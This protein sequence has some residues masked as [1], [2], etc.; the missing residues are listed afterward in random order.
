MSTK[1]ERWLLLG[2]VLLSLAL[3]FFFV[4]GP[5]VVWGDEPFYLW[6]GRNWLTGRG[7]Q[8]LGFTDVHHPPLYPLLSGMMYLV[9]RNLEAASNSLY[10]IFG[11][12]LVLPVYGIGR[13]LYGPRPGLLAGLLVALW[14]PF[15]AA[16]PW[17]GTMTEPPYY[18]FVA[19]GLWAAVVAAGLGGK[20]GAEAPTTNASAGGATGNRFWAWA[21]AG[22]AFGLAYLTRPEGLW[23]APAVGGA[24]LVV[25]W[26]RHMHWRG[27]A[28]GAA[29]FALGFLAGFV[30]YAI[31]TRINTG[32]WMVSEKVGITFQ[33]GL[34]IARGDMAEHDRVL[35]QLD[36][37]GKQVFFFSRESFHL[38]MMDQI[39]ADPRGYAGVLYLNAQNLLA[40]FFSVVDFV[41]AFL[42]LLGLGLFGMAWS[43]RRLYGELI[44]LAALLPPLT[45]LL[46]F[47]F[48]RYLSPMLL[49]MLVWTG[50]GLALMGDWLEETGMALQPRWPRL[51]RWISR[52]LLVLAVALILL[53]THRWTSL[54]VTG[55]QA[56]RPEHRAAGEWLAAHAPPDAVVMSRYPAIAFHADRRWIPSPNSEYGAALSYAAANGA[57]YWVVDGNESSL[58]PQ[59]ALLTDGP[60]PSEL[61]LVFST[62]TDGK[63]VYVYRIK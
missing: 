41:P 12:L 60:P 14:P 49:P 33:D 36:S 28:A 23:Y 18:F 1:R 29:L 6:I 37:S 34:A 59:L 7:Y 9:T 19:S 17:W 27:W 39:R 54:A 57:D 13:R 52:Y 10:L 51:W 5:R 47:I 62:P 21:L 56:V 40:S 4:R 42:P 2:L 58:R 32:S 38:S 24:L 45:F 8:F 25:A 46:F 15:N 48:A 11:P 44:L 22:V 20:S 50:L 3:H 43:R 16:V 30:P 35:Y 31:H 55:T 61:E 53:I 63:P 26:L